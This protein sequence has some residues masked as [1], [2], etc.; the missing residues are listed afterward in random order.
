MARVRR[1]CASKVS[2]LFFALSSVVSVVAVAGSTLSCVSP[3]LPLPPPS[4]PIIA[5]GTEPD[6]FRLTSVNGALPN[7]LI[8]IVNRNEALARDKR[9]SGTIADANGSWDATVVAK[10]GDALDISQESGTTTSPPITVTVR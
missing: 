3:T 7:A 10:V 1:R 4:A 9:V 2:A 5:T 6:T 8:V